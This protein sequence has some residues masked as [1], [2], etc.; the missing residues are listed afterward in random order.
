MEKKI[1]LPTFE[2]S[3]TDCL[4]R[5]G[6]VA[7]QNLFRQSQWPVVQELADQREFVLKSM[8]R[9]SDRSAIFLLERCVS[10]KA[11]PRNKGLAGSTAQEDRHRVSKSR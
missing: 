1:R 8:V 3:A 11:P 9:R 7:V 6:Q 4:F 10:R 5:V 2:S